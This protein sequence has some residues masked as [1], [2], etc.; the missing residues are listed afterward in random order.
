MLG[1][2]PT[3]RCLMSENNEVIYREF[4]KG[5]NVIFRDYSQPVYVLYIDNRKKIFSNI[6]ELRL[7][8]SLNLSDRKAET[9]KHK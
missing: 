9:V 5:N 2:V 8:H 3:L 1:S 7:C 6:Q 4:E